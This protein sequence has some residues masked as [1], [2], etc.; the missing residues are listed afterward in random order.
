MKDGTVIDPKEHIT[1]EVDTK[2]LPTK[3]HTTSKTDT[4]VSPTKEM[5]RLQY[6]VLF[7]RQRMR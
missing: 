1:S 7:A 4:E 5:I 2:V 3:E 6:G